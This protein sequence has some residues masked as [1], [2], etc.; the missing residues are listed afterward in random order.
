MLLLY[1]EN[2]HYNLFASIN[3]LLL[4]FS[5]LIE[6]FKFISSG[7][8]ILYTESYISKIYWKKSSLLYSFLIDN[9]NS[10]ILL[11]VLY[12]IGSLSEYPTTKLTNIMELLDNLINNYII[13]N[14]T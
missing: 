3:Y 6:V 2:F 5:L 10:K 11:G 1:Q 9:N 7:S 14:N 8:L 12:I 13:V 4:Y